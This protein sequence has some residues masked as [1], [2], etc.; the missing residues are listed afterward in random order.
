MLSINYVEIVVFIKEIF[1]SVWGNAHLLFIL[2]Y[3]LNN[4]AHKIFYFN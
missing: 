4:L 1:S 2:I 3:M